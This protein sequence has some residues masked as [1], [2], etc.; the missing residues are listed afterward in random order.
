MGVLPLQFKGAKMQL[1]IIL[2]VRKLFQLQDCQIIDPLKRYVKA[3]REDG[4]EVKFDV[5]AR[6]DSDIEVAYYQRG[7][8][9][10]YV[11]RQ[12]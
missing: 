9:L 8:I 11:L 7:G 12:F 4:S 6:V 3:T 10:Q 5:V 2:Q 1:R